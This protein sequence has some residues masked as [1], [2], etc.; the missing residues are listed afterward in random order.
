MWPWCKLF[1][2]DIETNSQY[3]TVYK[4]KSQIAFLE[5]C[6]IFTARELLW[7]LSLGLRLWLNHSSQ[8]CSSTRHNSFS[9]CFDFISFFQIA[10]TRMIVESL[11]PRHS[12]TCWYYR[13]QPFHPK[14]SYMI[15]TCCFFPSCL[16]YILQKGYFTCSRRKRLYKSSCCFSFRVSW[17]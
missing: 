17:W 16:Q 4:R 14:W 1:S 2:R 9:L 12:V 13:P 3:I 11:V 15:P 6:V 5:N 10:F 8:Q 7:V